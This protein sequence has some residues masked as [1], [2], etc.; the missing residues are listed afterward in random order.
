MILE[1]YFNYR[2]ELLDLWGGCAVTGCQ[3]LSVLIAS[4]IKA[5]KDCEEAERYD[6]YNGL[7]LTPCYDKVFDLYLISFADTGE[8][9]IFNSLFIISRGGIRPKIL[10]LNY[11]LPISIFI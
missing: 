5:Y 4:H 8:I 1:E 7:L 10:I 6:K 11:Q 2:N 9:M 3:N